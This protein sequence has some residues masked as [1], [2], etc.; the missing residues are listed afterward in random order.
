[1]NR[2]PLSFCLAVSHADVAAAKLWLRWATF[3][4]WQKD[5]D[6]SNRRLLVFL[7]KR[8]TNEDWLEIS[9]IIHGC[10]K[11]FKTTVMRCEDE[12]ERGYPGSSSHLFCRALQMFNKLFPGHAMMFCE[13]DTV[14]IRPAWAGELAA[15]YASRKAP[16]V[17][18]H[19]DSTRDAIDKFG[20]PTPHL[21][22]NAMYPPLALKLAPSIEQCLTART[23][24]CPWN[25]KGWAWDLFCAHEIVPESEQTD[26]I[27]QIWRSDPWTPALLNRLHPRTSLFHQSKDGTLIVSLAMRDYPKFLEHLPAPSRCYMLETGASE[28]QIGD[29]VFKFRK[30][31]RS[32]GKLICIFKPSLA[33]ED[34]LIGGLAGRRGITAIS[35]AEYDQL[36]A[37]A[38]RNRLD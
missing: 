32:M 27:Q 3:L 18:V 31:A 12:D 6:V 34:V 14:P 19:I 22:G 16:F 5:G 10:R 17:G 37:Q 4:S 29:H 33:F 23:D 8:V 36:A 26:R 28:V 30:A 9:T 21:T 20:M 24:N 35:Q 38:D 13:A 11:F 25:E 1:M 7:T 2:P 15:D